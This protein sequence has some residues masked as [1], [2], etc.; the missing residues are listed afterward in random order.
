MI[1]D[2]AFY[3]AAVVSVLVAGISKSGFGGGLG[4]LSVPLL[5]LVISPSQAAAILLPI[6]CLMY[7]LNAWHYRHTWDPVNLRILVPSG[8]VGVVIGTLTFRYFSEAHLRILI[9][10]I[11]LWFVL[12]YVRLRKDGE[13]QQANVWRGGFWGVVAG[14]TSFGMHAGGPPANIYLLPQRLDKGLFV[15][16]LVILFTVINYVKLIPYGLLGQLDGDNLLTSLVLAPLAP[17]GVVIGIRLHRWV[18][19]RV[20]YLICYVALGVTGIKLLVDGFQGL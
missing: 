8:L 6:L 3:L 19:E 17:I 10:A 1:T 12:Y 20:F 4:V 9:G 2:V 14:F 7:A 18:N 13:P 16:T 11:A 5:A 15:G